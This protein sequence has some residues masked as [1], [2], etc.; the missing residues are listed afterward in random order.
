MNYNVLQVLAV[1]GG[2]SL[3]EMPLIKN[4]HSKPDD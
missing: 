2:I 1:K 3:K 4:I